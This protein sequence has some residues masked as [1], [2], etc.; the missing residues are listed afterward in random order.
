MLKKKKVYS[1]ITA[2][3]KAVFSV[4]H[5]SAALFKTEQILKALL[6]KQ[7]SHLLNVL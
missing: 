1:V 5:G 7:I 3:F 4:R 6:C 2:L